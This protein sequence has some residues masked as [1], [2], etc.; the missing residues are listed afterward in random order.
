[1]RKLRLTPDCRMHL[2]DFLLTL[3]KKRMKRLLSLLLACVAFTTGDAQHQENTLQQFN[4][5]D[6]AL[7]RLQHLPRNRFWKDTTKELSYST[8]YPKNPKPGVH[9]LPLDN[10][11][12]LVP[13]PNTS[14]AIINLWKGI[15][16]IPFR[17]PTQA[18]PNPALP[19][20]NLPLRPLPV[21]PSRPLLQLPDTK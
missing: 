4:Q 8:V 9:R 12:C 19:P 17:S 18:I 7:K 16:S 1:M 20:T 13:D 14:V 5:N 10:M 15:S 2:H 21:T 3:V 6:A 11:P